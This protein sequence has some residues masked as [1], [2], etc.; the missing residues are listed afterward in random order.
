MVIS[1]IALLVGILLPALAK[2]RESAK[3]ALCL[4]NQKQI[5]ISTAV[6]QYDY[7]DHFAVYGSSTGSYQ[8]ISWDDLYS[9][10][11][12]RHLTSAEKS[13]VVL[14]KQQN[15][16][17]VCPSDTLAAS[18]AWSSAS[19]RRTYMPTTGGWNGSPSATQRGITSNFHDSWNTSRR[20][21]DL[22]R[23]SSTITFIEKPDSLNLYGYAHQA[24]MGWA[25]ASPRQETA[26]DLDLLTPLHNS[27]SNW[28]FLLADGHVQS[29]TLEQSL[30]K[31]DGTFATTANVTNS[32]WDAWR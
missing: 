32:L 3:A 22:S 5:G 2:A 18:T 15:N 19:Q 12:G 16:M 4:S 23:P 1:I 17:Y 30:K 14:T 31:D 21:S 29:M 6:Y 7:K 9:E 8:W 11:D 26:A 13:Q 20:I 10:Y 28:N 27:N 24:H 25:A